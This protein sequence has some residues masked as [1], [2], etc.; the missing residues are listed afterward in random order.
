MMMMAKGGVRLT[1]YQEWHLADCSSGGQEG[2]LEGQY[3]GV[4][5]GREEGQRQ[6]QSFRSKLLMAKGI[7]RVLIFLCRVGDA[8]EGEIITAAYITL[9][10][11]RGE[12]MGSST[13]NWSITS[14]G[15]GMAR[16]DVARR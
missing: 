3:S 6:G 4:G 16:F 8:S 11:R 1:G 9:V 15:G 14:K 7:C 12:R 13:E 2:K 10:P 5:Q